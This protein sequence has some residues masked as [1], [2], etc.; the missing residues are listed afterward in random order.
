[1]R[2]LFLLIG[3]CCMVAGLYAQNRITDHRI[4]LSL[5]HLDKVLDGELSELIDALTAVQN[6]AKNGES[7]V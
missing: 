6:A 7:A 5:Y 3:M 2:K 4:S 1:M